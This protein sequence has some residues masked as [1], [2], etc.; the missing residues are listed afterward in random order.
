ML[1]DNN[2]VIK[3]KQYE[4]PLYIGD[5]VNCARIFNA[6]D[7]DELIIIDISVTKNKKDPNYLLIKDIAE[8]VFCPLSYGG[9][10]RTLK[11][12]KKIFNLG[13]EKIIINAQAHSDIKFISQLTKKFGSQSIS[14]A[15]DIIHEN[16]TYYL[17]DYLNSSKKKQDIKDYLRKVEKANVGE[18]I[19]NHVALEGTLKGYDI[20]LMKLFKETSLQVIYN[21]GINNI[22]NLKEAIIQT[23]ITAFGVGSLFCLLKN[24]VL[25]SYVSLSERKNLIDELGPDYV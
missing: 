2:K 7:I 4:K 18:I 1:I 11:Q 8:E 5:P 3:T 17:Y 19:I 10:I 15:I 12:A 20:S 22:L 25:L 13:V 24:S 9:G 16:G 23:S 6:K 21:G 14:V